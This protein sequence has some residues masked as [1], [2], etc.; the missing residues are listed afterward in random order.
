M[1]LPTRLDR[2]EADRRRQRTAYLH[3]R[4]ADELGVPV[5]QVDAASKEAEAIVQVARRRS[6]P[7]ALPGDDLVDLTPT[8]EACAAAYQL[9]PGELLAEAE[10]IAGWVAEWEGSR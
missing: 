4:I 1:N 2:L 8:L 3:G 10:R 7:V 5:A 9:D 6:P